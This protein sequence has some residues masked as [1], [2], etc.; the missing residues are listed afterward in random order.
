VPIGLG[1]GKVFKAGNVVFNLF[2][3]PQFTVLAEGIWQPRYQ[4]F[5]GFNTQF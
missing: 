2:A 3:E 5:I 1:V 4:T